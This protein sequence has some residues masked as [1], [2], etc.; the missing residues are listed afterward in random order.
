MMTEK[1]GRHMADLEKEFCHALTGRAVWEKIK[2]KHGIAG[3]CG[4]VIFPSADAAV[5]HEAAAL[6]P[7]YMERTF[8]QKTVAATDQGEV[9]SMLEKAGHR[10]VRCESLTHV[11][12]RRLLK[13]YRL[14]SFWTFTTV[15][16]LEEPFGNVSL[17]HNKELDLGS[18]ILSAIYK[19]R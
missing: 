17:L 16:S 14:V 6:L 8:L 3:R 2:K 11:E 1:Q 13:Y 18:Y 10:D 12:M 15:V 7:V 9:V 4:L 19:V 5:N